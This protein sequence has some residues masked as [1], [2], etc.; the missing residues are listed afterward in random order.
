[1]LAEAETPP[2]SIDLLVAGVQLE[3]DT[4]R[5]HLSIAEIKS[6]FDH[7]HIDNNEVRQRLGKL[8]MTDED[9]ADL[10]VVW[11]DGKK[12]ARSGIGTAKILGYL[13]GEVIDKTTAYNHL[14]ANGMRPQDAQFLVD[15]PT[16][17]PHVTLKPVSPATVVAAYKDD[18]LGID[19]ARA[20]L[21]KLNISQTQ[22]ELLLANATA[23]I[24]KGKKP[25]QPTKTL[26]D[27]HVLDALKFGLASPTWVERELETL[28]Y[29][30]DDASLLTMLEL[31]KLDPKNLDRYGWQVLT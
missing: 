25:K 3:R 24:T 27:G 20:E 2:E 16:T 9:I 14:I 22:R 5:L 26:T 31:A 13:I 1:M 23:I 11:N 29:S 6:L 10:L 21:A 28:G 12:A 30:A 7:A 8:G 15:H 4:G 17:H 19:E 18:V